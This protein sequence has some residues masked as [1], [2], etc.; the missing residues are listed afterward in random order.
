MT[1]PDRNNWPID[2]TA[3]VYGRELV[4][5]NDILFLFFGFCFRSIV[6]WCSMNAFCLNSPIL[7]L[8]DFLQY[9]AARL[10]RV[11]GGRQEII[12]RGTIQ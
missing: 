9:H 11:L 1:A 8:I 12:N 2:P 3:R 4:F 6:F 7:F 5:W 10:H